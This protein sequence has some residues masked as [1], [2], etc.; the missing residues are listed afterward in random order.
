MSGRGET[1]EEESESEATEEAMSLSLGQTLY[2]E[3]GEPVE[4]GRAHV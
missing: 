2:D 4:I 1:P 3:N